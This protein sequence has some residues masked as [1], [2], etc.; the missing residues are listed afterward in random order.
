MT[1][2]NI[3]K[4]VGKDTSPVDNWWKFTTWTAK[5]RKGGCKLYLTWL[6]KA[7]DRPFRLFIALEQI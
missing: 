3:L 2:L 5:A 1:L 7:D 4:A 6:K